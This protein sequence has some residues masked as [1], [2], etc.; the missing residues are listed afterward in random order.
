MIPFRSSVL[1]QL[2]HAQP[3][4]SFPSKSG[5]SVTEKIKM[6]SFRAPSKSESLLIGLHHLPLCNTRS[7]VPIYSLCGVHQSDVSL[8]KRLCYRV[9]EYGSRKRNSTGESL[10]LK[11]FSSPCATICDPSLD[12]PRGFSDSN[13]DL[14]SEGKLWV[15]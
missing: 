11:R 4:E 1:L 13:S 2:A 3:P 9:W 10:D 6:P 12:K 8:W 7:L 14:I 15:L 5:F